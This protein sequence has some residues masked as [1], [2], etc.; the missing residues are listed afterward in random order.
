MD[1]AEKYRPKTLEDIIGNKKTINE[2]EDW[3]K[4]WSEKKKKEKGAIIH[5]PP[6]IGKTSA[7]LALA[8]KYGYDTIEMNA[9]DVRNY[10]SVRRIAMRGAVN[11]SLF[12]ENQKKLII[13]DEADNLSG[14]EDR[15]GIKAITETLEVTKQP[16]ILI[17]NDL[18]AL[19]S[20]SQ[21]FNEHCLILKF[22]R[23][24][25]DEIFRL[26]KKIAAAESIEMDDETLKE[27][28]DICN[29]DIRSA[30]RDLEGGG[31]SYRDREGNIFNVLPKIFKSTDVHMIRTELMSLD[32]EPEEVLLW[33][34][35]NLPMVFDG[36][37]LEKAYEQTCRID[38]YIGRVK[39]RQHYTLWRYANAL[40][41]FGYLPGHGARYSYPEWLRK[42]SRYKSK[43]ALRESVIRKLSFHASSRKTKTEILPYLRYMIKKDEMLAASIAE[44]FELNNE[45]LDFLIGE[46]KKV[47]RSKLKNAPI[48]KF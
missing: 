34:D 9:S 41:F 18:Y 48:D 2:L 23:P 36:K 43:R 14:I 33:I 45:E 13:L 25:K 39:R 12:S 20:R 28:A 11:D 22:D 44:K 16:I 17:A 40:M 38:I 3:L 7:A 5:G 35:E 4:G 37:A 27:I 1:L 15:G 10:E 30:I 46:T 6:G 32:K 29:G 8:K 26:L 21:S 19:T 42:M 24:R 31:Q 47:S